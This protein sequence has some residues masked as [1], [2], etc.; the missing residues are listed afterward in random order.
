[1]SSITNF[2]FQGQP[3]PPQPTGAD[4][5]SN[6]PL[7]YQQYL[8]NTAGAATSLASQPYQASPNPLVA[9]PSSQTQQSWQMANNDVG[10][11]QPALGTAGALTASAAAPLSLNT[12][13]NYAG[14]AGTGIGAMGS[15]IAN[16]VNSTTQGQIGNYLNPNLDFV[17]KG[18][19]SQL[20]NNL[21]QNILPGIQDRYVASGQSASPQQMQAENNASYQT[22]QALGQALAPVYQQAYTGALGAA[23]NATNT[24]Y[25]LG[26]YAYGLGT[27]TGQGQQT[28]QQT[29]GAQFGQL[30]ALNAQLGAADVSQVAGAGAGQDSINQANLT[31]LNTQFANQQQYPYQ[32]LGFLS[33]LLRGNALPT[34]QS[35]TALNYSPYSTNSASPLQAGIG[36]TAAIGALGSGTKLAARGGRIGKAM[37]GITGGGRL[38]MPHLPEAKRA[39][40]VLNMAMAA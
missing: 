34:T 30:G 16:G 40:G 39:K 22:Q 23:Q 12:I 32:Q 36:T 18:I 15:G 38:P 3:V 27:S 31:A 24:G 7:W 8:S 13:G 10:A 4:T 6:F 37:G 33:N 1:M 25:G 29:A 5:T 21:Q 11:W 20:N 26:Q 2:L 19:E 14:G 9:P 35:Q 28:Q 17:S